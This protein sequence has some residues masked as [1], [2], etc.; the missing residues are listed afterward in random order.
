[1]NSFE[2]IVSFAKRRGFIFQSSEIYGGLSSCY[3]YGPLGVE[4]KN[5]VKKAWW[6]AM[7]QERN[8]VVGLDS[9]I[10]MHPKTWEASGHLAGFT[11]PLVDCKECKKRFRADHLL[12]AKGITPDFRP[13]E[14]EK[15]EMKCPDCG[16]ELTDV[17]NFN[18]MFKTFMGALED[19]ASQ[20]YL[21]PETCQG[22]YVNFPNIQQSM[23]KKIP[24]GVA[25]IGKAFRN[26]ITPGHFTFRTREFEQMEQQYFIH[27]DDSKKYFEM[28]KDIRMKWYESLGMKKEN[29]RFRDHEGDELAHYAKAAVDIEYNYPGM[30]FKELAGVHD[31]G[32]WDL[33]RHEEY[34]KEKMSYLDQQ[35]NNERFIPQIIETSDG[36]DRSAL[37]FLMD[38]YEEV[39]TR[40]GADDA[41]HTKE[42]VLRLHKDLA[43]IKI[44]IL[45]L[46]K[47]EPLQKLSKEIQ[48]D[49]WGNW[50]TQYDETGSVGKR[51]RR[52]DEI[53]TPYCVTID[54]DSLEDKKVTVRDRDTM[55]QERIDIAD[56]K[57]YFIEKF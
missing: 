44:A 40:S 24:F 4:L 51:Y 3:D 42:V 12:E 31:R 28:W 53:G 43:P 5:N 35:N 19:E 9:S 36:A 26:E 46:S 18:L 41:K 17:R 20:I 34:S 49:L 45:P 32:T 30:G 8:D 50:M 56:L 57:H 29:I 16:G 10:L 7:V 23:R 38:A 1:M 48:S 55:E 27:P 25:Q 54:F 21:R 13:G 22:I 33:S 14:W 15:N 6:K 2:N 37:A 39:E 47:K 11:D 52:Q